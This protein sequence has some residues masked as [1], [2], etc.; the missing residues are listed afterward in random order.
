MNIKELGILISHMEDAGFTHRELNN[1]RIRKAALHLL[2]VGR[3]TTPNREAIIDKSMVKRLMVQHG[4]TH[5][6][7]T[8]IEEIAEM[9][10]HMGEG[11][12]LE[13][14]VGAIREMKS[15]DKGGA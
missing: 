3:R 1:D 14:Y 10:D 9:V 8:L 5:D 15:G 11:R 7:D 13:E 12:R 2:D 6:R 4:L